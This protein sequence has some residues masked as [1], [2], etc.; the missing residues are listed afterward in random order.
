MTPL[1]EAIR[2]EIAA[3]GP[4]RLD[5]YMALCLGHPEHGYY[6]RREPFGRGGDFVTAPEISQMF[7]ELLGLWAAQVWLDLGRPASFALVELGPGRGVLMAD[8][9]RAARAVPG[10]AEAA[11]VWLVETSPALRAEQARRVP[12]ARWAARIEDVPPGPAIVLANEFFD[13]LP[14]R[15]F[16]RRPEGWRERMVGVAEDRLVWGLGPAPDGLPPAPVGAVRETC[17]AAAAVAGVIGARLAADG[18]AALI[19]DYGAVPPASGG[20]DTLQA[21]ARHAAADPLAAPGEVDLT[22]HV[23]F[24]A[25]AVV[26]AAAGASVAPLATQGALLGRLGIETRAAALARANPAR[27]AAVIAAARR[28]TDP[29]AMGTL[30]KALAATGPGRPPPP[31]FAREGET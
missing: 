17:A 15:Q 11:V 3:T 12:G 7:G 2:A 8:A 29:A 10:F 14:I 20:G 26:L 31:G 1:A 22:A 21:V 27:A 5:R 13:A 9:L 19:L 4:M 18:G 24:G 25:L 16:H 6:M 23:D 30:F 28:L